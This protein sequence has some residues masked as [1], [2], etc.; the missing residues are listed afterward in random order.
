MAAAVEEASP[1]ALTFLTGGNAAPGR[2]HH[3]RPAEKVFL[4]SGPKGLSGLPNMAHLQVD[5]AQ[6]CVPELQAHCTFVR[7]CGVMMELQSHNSVVQLVQSSAA[8]PCNWKVPLCHNRLAL[9]LGLFPNVSSL[10]EHIMH[11]HNSKVSWR[12]PGRC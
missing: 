11:G 2:Q 7:P 1:G 5:T 6:H 10:Q 8:F 12:H 3:H 4:L 9:Q